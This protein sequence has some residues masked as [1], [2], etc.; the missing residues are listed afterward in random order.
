MKQYLER[1]AHSSGIDIKLEDREVSLDP[2]PSL[3][4]DLNVKAQNSA[5]TDA[6]WN[7]H[8]PM[9]KTST[10]Q[11]VSFAL[12]EQTPSISKFIIGEG[13]AKKYEGDRD[14]KNRS[15]ETRDNSIPNEKYSEF[16]MVEGRLFSKHHNAVERLFEEVARGFS[17]DPEM[18]EF[19]M[20]KSGNDHSRSIVD[21]IVGDEQKILSEKQWD[22]LVERVT[23]P[24]ERR[25]R[26][27]QEIRA[28]RQLEEEKKCIFRP[29]INK[30]SRKLASGNLP[31]IERQDIILS[32]RRSKIEMKR[33]EKK[34]AEEETL[35]FNP[36]INRSS[37][38]LQ[39]GTQ[40]FEQWIQERQAK[41]EMML[42][43]KQEMEVEGCTFRPTL[44]NRS[45][46]VGISK[47]IFFFDGRTSEMYIYYFF[48]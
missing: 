47:R 10:Q 5:S 29:K 8:A 32:E 37:K 48:I 7:N 15:N 23:R 12:R 34:A 27:I 39:R 35:K 18:A 36:N 42:K 1:A 16:D 41:R 22:E 14:T 45:L 9:V 43:G 26:R 3:D 11:S 44:S 46:K 17:D 6:S 13:N 40:L 2:E 21:Q 31:L 19:F 30:K 38:R 24:F 20:E 33:K 4:S 25:E 28:Q